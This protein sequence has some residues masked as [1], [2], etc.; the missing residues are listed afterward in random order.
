MPS[1]DES[2]LVP[3][4]SA[5]GGTAPN[6]E[7]PLAPPFDDSPPSPPQGR[8][9]GSITPGATNPADMAT[10]ESLA[11]P[12][13]RIQSALPDADLPPAMP[14]DDPFKDDPPGPPIP[15][16]EPTKRG[17]GLKPRVEKNV[18]TAAAQWQSTAK[19][20]EAAVEG[21]QLTP[22]S[23]A[24]EP[25][26]LRPVEEKA[27]ASPVLPPASA[28]PRQNPLRTAARDRHSDRVLPTA[29]WSVDQPAPSVAATAAMRRNPLRSN[30]IESMKQP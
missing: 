29:S 15:A 16:E 26:R 3:T 4:D 13:S 18:R 10:P 27:E 22:V 25:R 12:P 24:E 20:V 8:E 17:A 30:S 9:S 21:P 6:A 23:S 7:P 19:P 14:D 28:A 2:P 11:E 5:P 1:M